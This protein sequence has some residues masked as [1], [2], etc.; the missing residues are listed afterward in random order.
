MPRLLAGNSNSPYWPLIGLRAGTTRLRSPSSRSGTWVLI[1]FI[2]DWRS[3]HKL[4][5]ATESGQRAPI[6]G[7]HSSHLNSVAERGKSLSALP[8]LAAHRESRRWSNWATPSMARCRRQ[9]PDG[10]CATQRRDRGEHPPAS[11]P[12][13]LACMR[14]H[15]G[16]ASGWDQP[17][18]TPP[19]PRPRW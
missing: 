19:L 8:V 4:A 14:W 13:H 3:R 1:E 9:R 11:A 15:D 12:T 6:T 5:G 7:L 2:C 16:A 18:S 10:G 17:L